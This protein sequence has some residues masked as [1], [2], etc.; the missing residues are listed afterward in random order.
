MPLHTESALQLTAMSIRRARESGPTPFGSTTPPANTTPPARF[1]KAPSIP[2]PPLTPSSEQKSRTQDSRTVLEGLTQEIE[3]RKVGCGCSDNPW[4]RFELSEAAYKHWLQQHQQDRFV[5]HKLRYDY[6]ASASLFVLRMPTVLHED[7][8][9]SI[10]LDVTRQLS[11]IASGAGPVADF[12][13]SIR[14]TGSGKI[15]FDDSSSTHN[16]DASFKHVQARYPG[17]VVEVSYSQKRKDLPR[18]ADDYI[19]GSD[20]DIRVVI[21]VDIGYRD[22]AAALSIWRPQIQVNDAGEAELVAH[23]TLSDQVCSY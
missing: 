6:F 12:A 17:V 8:A 13:K 23:Q 18:L 7:L 22:K 21:G 2:P 15:T 3:N 20:G 11:S 14:P 19:L 1:T 9:L 5:K 4:L 16:P 10:V